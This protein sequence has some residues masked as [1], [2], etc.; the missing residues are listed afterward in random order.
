MN[1][2]DLIARFILACCV[3]HNICIMKGDD[4]NVPQLD[5]EVEN[6]IFREVANNVPIGVI[7]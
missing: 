4:L 1:K 3:M 7:K 5:D 2:T 6:N